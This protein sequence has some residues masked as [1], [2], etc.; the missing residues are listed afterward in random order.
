MHF[1]RL[2]LL[3]Y[4]FFISLLSFF[5]F[6]QLVLYT[7]K[8]SFIWYEIG[9]RNIQPQKYD[10]AIL[11]DSQLMSGV[12]PLF[13]KKLLQE[14][15]KPS[16]ILYYPRP[17]EQPEGIYNMLLQFKKKEI[18]FKTLIVNI[19]PVTT[20][21]NIIVDSHKSLVLNFQPFSSQILLEPTLNK[22]YLK[23]IS[24]NLYYLFI[25]VFPLLKLNGNIS[26]EMKLIPGSEG[27]QHDKEIKSFLNMPFTGN[28][29]SNKNRNIFLDKYL[30]QENFFF[31][32]GNFSPFT[33][34]CLERLE[35]LLLPSGIEAAFLNPRTESLQFWIKLGEYAQANNFKILFL[36]TPFSPESELKIGSNLPTSPIQISLHEISTRFGKDSI[37]KIDSSIFGSKDFKDYTHLNV[38]GMIKLTKEIANRL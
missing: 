21:K 35:P 11:G 15:N 9:K 22:F 16:D 27:I 8:T 29:L 26:N 18:E 23:N 13:L 3:L 28:L 38:C 5:L 31:E 10:V 20:S 4:L 1:Y 37:L 12:H 33:G 17:S 34:E 7:E 25:Q 19:S 36:Y 32:W 6:H 30:T 24:G 2:N 14:K